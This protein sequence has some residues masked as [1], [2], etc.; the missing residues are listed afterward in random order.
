MSFWALTLV[1]IFYKIY[2]RFFFYFHGLLIK[3]MN[4]VIASPAILEVIRAVVKGEI[5]A[6]LWTFQSAP[7]TGVVLF[8]MLKCLFPGTLTSQTRKPVA[9]CASMCRAPSGQQLI[10]MPPGCLQEGVWGKRH[11]FSTWTLFSDYFQYSLVLRKLQLLFRKG[12][13]TQSFGAIAPDNVLWQPVPNPS[14]WT[15]QGRGCGGR[16]PPISSRQSQWTSI[17]SS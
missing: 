4:W 11:D 1:F 6:I 16:V 2:K 5:F 15:A 3:T 13:E 10:L 12:A 9:G 17:S 8:V 7:N 14:G